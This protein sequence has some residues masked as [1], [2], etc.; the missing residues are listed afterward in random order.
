MLSALNVNIVFCRPTSIIENWQPMY[1]S[2]HAQRYV[3]QMESKMLCHGKG[4]GMFVFCSSTVIAVS[5]NGGTWAFTELE[6]PFVEPSKDGSQDV[7][8]VEVVHINNGILLVVNGDIVLAEVSKLTTG[9]LLPNQLPRTELQ[10][11]PLRH[12]RTGLASLQKQVRQIELGFDG[13]Q[14]F[15]LVIAEDKPVEKGR[16]FG[17]ETVNKPFS[18]SIMRITFDNQTDFDY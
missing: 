16:Q 14:P 3:E 10:I 6:F 9:R 2:K 7:S 5:W 11:K 17:E 15:F 12:F 18:F 8:H 1:C 13:G 4:L